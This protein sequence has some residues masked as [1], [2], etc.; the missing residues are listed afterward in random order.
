MLLLLK[1]YIVIS[2]RDPYNNFNNGRI[3]IADLPTKLRAYVGQYKW[4]SVQIE[5][6][7]NKPI[8]AY[9]S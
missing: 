9:H 8:K 7:L 3:N 1:L 6:Q 4:R 2:Q 5:V